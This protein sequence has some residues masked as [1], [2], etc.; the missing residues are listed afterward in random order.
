V[1][2]RDRSGGVTNKSLRAA[3]RNLAKLGEVTEIQGY[4]FTSTR[5]PK[6]FGAYTTQH[7]C[8][9]LSGPRGTHRYEGVLWGYYGEGPRGLVQILEAC[10]LNVQAAEDIAFNTPRGNKNGTDFII[11]FPVPVRVQPNKIY[12]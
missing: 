5:K 4:R 8:L 11:K 12:G 3:K 6:G 10:G 9:R 7:E 1:R 2:Y